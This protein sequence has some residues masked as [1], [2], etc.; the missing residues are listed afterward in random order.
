MTLDA[1]PE[2]GEGMVSGDVINTAARLQS[3]AP[4]GGILVGDQ[5]YRATE[6]AIEYAEHV[7]VEAKG[8]AAPVTVW[9]ATAVVPRSGGTWRT[10]ERRRSSAASASS[11]CSPTRSTASGA[12]IVRSS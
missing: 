11:R 7:A 6:R 8:K 3:A 9:L 12:R 10:L 1:R 2:A 5:T 4:P